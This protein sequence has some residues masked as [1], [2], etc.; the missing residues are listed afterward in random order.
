MMKDLLGYIISLNIFVCGKS[1]L[2]N[3]LV[4]LHKMR[5]P[6]CLFHGKRM[7]FKEVVKYLVRE[8]C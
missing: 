6:E 3:D 7:K 4:I 2:R 8:W 5:N 1:Q